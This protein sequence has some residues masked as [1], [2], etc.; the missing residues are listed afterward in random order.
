MH[1]D[2]SLDLLQQSLRCLSDQLRHFQR[3]TCAA[4]HTHELPNQVAQQQRREMAE[5]A[6]GHQKKEPRS[7]LLPKTFYQVLAVEQ[8]SVDAKEGGNDYCI[9]LAVEQVYY[10]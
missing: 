4:F 9:Y 6:A 10:T 7:A 1:T 2:E 5:Y 3:H 8:V